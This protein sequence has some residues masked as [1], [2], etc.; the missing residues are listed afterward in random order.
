M[1]MRFLY[2][3]ILGLGQPSFPKG[4]PSKPCWRFSGI[5]PSAPIHVL[6][7]HKN[8]DSCIMHNPAQEW[9]K[10]VTRGLPK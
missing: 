5:P 4:L 7:P 6:R 1:I 9:E 8:S 2:V 10:E 3:S